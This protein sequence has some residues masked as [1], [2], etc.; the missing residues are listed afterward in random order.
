LGNG[1]VWRF[2]SSLFVFLTKITLDQ[3]YLLKSCDLFLFEQVDWQMV[4]TI[5]LD[6]SLKTHMSHRT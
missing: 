2:A 5:E 1:S 4:G 6:T 3:T